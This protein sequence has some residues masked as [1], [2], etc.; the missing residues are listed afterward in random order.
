[1]GEMP[2]NFSVN[3]IF[4]SEQTV[5]SLSQY[6]Y[7]S[8]QHKNTKQ[9]KNRAVLRFSELPGS[10]RLS[11]KGIQHEHQIGNG[12]EAVAVKVGCCEHI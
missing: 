7:I 2:L 12:Q 4:E 5:D 1:M 10:V 6:F 9:I 8:S 11:G 3:F